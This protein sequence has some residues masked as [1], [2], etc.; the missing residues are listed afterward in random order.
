MNSIYK[1]HLRPLGIALHVFKL[2]QNV[3]DGT[4]LKDLDNLSFMEKKSGSCKK[5]NT[6]LLLANGG[7][8]FERA[9]EIGRRARPTAWNGTEDQRLTE[10][11]NGTTSIEEGC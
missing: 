6:V 11:T 4:A 8:P 9:M 1:H 3:V 7:V 5:M 10:F 2:H